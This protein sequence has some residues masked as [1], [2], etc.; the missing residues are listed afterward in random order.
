VLGLTATYGLPADYQYLTVAKAL[1]KKKQKSHTYNLYPEGSFSH[2]IKQA[3][4]D[5]GL[6]KQQLANEL[7][8]SLPTLTYYFTT[9]RFREPTPYAMALFLTHM[10]LPLKWKNLLEIKIS[11]QSTPVAEPVPTPVAEPVPTPVAE[12]VPTPVAEPCLEQAEFPQPSFWN[13]LKSFFG[14]N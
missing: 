7:G 4:L 13:R 14:L 11:D 6:T 2:D 5:R 3:M 1:A 8:I 12:P 10:E 9:Y